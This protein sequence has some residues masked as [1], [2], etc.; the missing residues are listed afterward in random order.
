M[1]PF[2]ENESEAEQ[3]E[4]PETFSLSRLVPL[5]LLVAGLIAFFAFDLDSYLTFDTLKSNREFLTA[6][7]AGQHFLAALI[8]IGIY[9]V[10]VAFS[11]PGGA[12]M[13]ITGGFLFGWLAAAFYI[14][15][16]ATIGATILFLAAKTALADSLRARAGGMVRKMEDGFRENAF[17]YLLVLRLV[18]LFPFWLVNLVPAL[19]GVRL[20]TY[21]IATFIGIMP[22]TAVYASVG[23]GLGVL[24]DRGET[25]DL[26]IVFEPS[27]FLPLLGLAVLAMVPIVYNKMMASK[28]STQ[29]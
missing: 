16:G 9:I 25:P 29:K 7:V 17:N 4:R 28:S 5:V 14:V 6:Y 22:G 1:T 15:I 10:V 12:V 19:L 3:S 2:Q 27:I 11:L 20:R 13:S 18:P 8:F 23:N 21:V 24:F 26:G